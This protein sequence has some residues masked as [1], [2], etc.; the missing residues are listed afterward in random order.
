MLPSVDT[1]ADP[2]RSHA[3][4]GA[5]GRPGSLKRFCEPVGKAREAQHQQQLATVNQRI[6]MPGEF[7]P[8]CAFRGE[9]LVIDMEGFK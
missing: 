9:K 4:S 5:T 2:S 6:S 8:A 3:N 1:A 7:E